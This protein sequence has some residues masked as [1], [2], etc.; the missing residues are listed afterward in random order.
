MADPPNPDAAQRVER[1]EREV[2]LLQKKLARS[3]ANRQLIEQAKDRF[4]ALSRG[5]IAELEKAQEELRRAKEVAEEATR[6][7]SDF[8]ANM[9]HEIRTPMNAIIGMAHLALRT[10]LDARQ[11][12]YVTKIQLAGQHLLG[13]IN[14]ILDFSKIESGHLTVESVAF[15]LEN[16]LASV[17]DFVSEKAAA[18]GL[19]LL[20]DVDAR[21]PNDLRGDP[22][23]LGQVLIN[24]ASNAVKFTD[25]GSLVVRVQ[26]AEEDV[27]SVLLRF[28][29]EDTGIGLT[30]D[31]IDRLFQSFS[32]ADY[33]DDAQI[34]R[35]WSGARHQQTAG[36]SHGR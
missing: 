7:K 10:E 35:H 20:V 27:S 24:Y 19:E 30:P 9:S 17:S 15:E 36:A 25:E 33:I 29:V 5:V 14:D 34:W 8:L 13:L 18:K 6:M 11:R 12:D 1:L 2:R 16:V 3:D 21:V 23:R 4:D 31:Q 26:L 32:Q 22:L 28:E